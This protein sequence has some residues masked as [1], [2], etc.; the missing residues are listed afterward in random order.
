MLKLGNLFGRS[1]VAPLQHHL[2]KVS[3]CLGL[4][5]PLFE[6]V[7]VRDEK[8]VNELIQEI[9]KAEYAADLMKKDLRAK[10]PRSLFLSIDRNTLLD[11]LSLQ[12]SIA[13]QAEDVAVLTSFRLIEM[14][15]AVEPLFADF[16]NKNLNTFRLV[17]QVISELDE[18]LEASFIGVEAEHVGKLIHAVEKEEYETDLAQAALLRQ[19]YKE[20]D[21]LPYASFYH[22]QQTI[23]A[24]S[25]IS[26]LSEKLAHQMRSTLEL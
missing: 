15:P 16:F 13:D 12:D 19:L 20:S 21:T 25:G 2:A 11:I 1:P 24:L 9:S 22:W 3:E 23:R 14:S 6:A 17:E 18:L 26:N 8:R 5:R 7:K 10:L 4:L